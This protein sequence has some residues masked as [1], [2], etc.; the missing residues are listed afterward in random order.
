MNGYRDKISDTTKNSKIKVYANTVVK[1]VNEYVKNMKKIKIKYNL[2]AV[3]DDTESE[4]IEPPEKKR[5]KKQSIF[6]KK[7]MILKIT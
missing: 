2:D 1:C 4:E 7:N 5:K 6:S 3:E